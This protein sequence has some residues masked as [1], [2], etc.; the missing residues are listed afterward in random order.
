MQQLL[1]MKKALFL[2]CLL[3][4]GLSAQTTTDDH[5]RARSSFRIGSTSSTAATG[6]VNTMPGSPSTQLITA[7]GVYNWA[8]GSLNFGGDVSGLYNSLTLA[9][10]GV[11]AGTC[12]NCSL[13]IDAKGRVTVKGSGSAGATYTAGSGIAISGGNEISN[14]GDLSNT[15][16]LQSLGLAGQ[17]LTI[18]GGSGATLPVVGVSAGNGVT[19]TPVAGVYTITNNISNATNGLAVSA[20]GALSAPAMTGTGTWITGGS[21]TTNKPYFLL[22]PTGTT[23]AAWNINGTGLGVNAASGSTADLM[24]LQLNGVSR[25][26]VSSAGAGVFAGGVTVSGTL[27]LGSASTIIWSSRCRI[28]SPSTSAIAMFNSSG[29]D[30]SFLQFG[31]TTSSFPS[32][33]KNGTVMENRLADDS[34]F[35]AVQSLYDRFG[36]GSPEGV[37]SAPVGAVYHNTTGGTG[38]AVYHKETG[39]TGN[40][41]WVAK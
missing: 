39:G 12:T 5:I 16:E 17:S 3:T 6:I 41:G 35:A 28:T 34:G 38:T 27:S 37:V 21:A 30:F 32:L 20:N 11:T 23:S 2:L 4:T 24:H 9:N 36:S 1:I 40:T 10:S 14:T 26:S 8:T 19:V 18:S 29:S 13:T 31:G 7:A 15:N 22:E 25:F 33:K